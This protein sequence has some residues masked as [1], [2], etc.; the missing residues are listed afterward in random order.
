MKQLEQYYREK[1]ELQA[2]YP[3]YEC[4]TA[5]TMQVIYNSYGFA[6]WKFAEATKKLKTALKNIL[7]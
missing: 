7:K 2:G 5:E 1:L 4:L 3:P 6:L